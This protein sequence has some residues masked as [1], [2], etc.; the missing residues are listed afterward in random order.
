MGE[1]DW[2][3]RKML[4]RWEKSKEAALVD[5]SA[6]AEADVD[7]AKARLNNANQ[8]RYQMWAGRPAMTPDKET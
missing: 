3:V 4:R 8:A 1:L 5:E 2:F 7:R 6:S